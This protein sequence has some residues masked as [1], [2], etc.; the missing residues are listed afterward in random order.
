MAT[1]K[2]ELQVT[3]GNFKN[4]GYIASR[5]VSSLHGTETHTEFIGTHEESFTPVYM[6][7]QTLVVALRQA[8]KYMQREQL[9]QRGTQSMEIYQEDSAICNRL[10]AWY[11]GGGVEI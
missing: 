9:A 4:H 5:C 11:L 1:N 7:E 2:A 6:R 3:Y 8:L 10:R